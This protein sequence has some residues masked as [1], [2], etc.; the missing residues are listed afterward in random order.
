MNRRDP[1]V[2]R[3]LSSLRRRRLAFVVRETAARVTRIL[4]IALG[5]LIL[6]AGAVLT[7]LPGHVGLPLL[8]LGLMVVLRNS[9]QARRRFIRWQKRHPK[10][11]FPI[12]RLMRREPE[13][14][15]VAWQQLLRSEKVVLRRPGW[16]VL[17][18]GRKAVR[19]ALGKTPL[20]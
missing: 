14:L 4:L 6:L 18:R 13:I 15:L 9:F 12:R 11:I 8:V 19:K 1:R 20:S 5:V 7:P 16:R 10:L 3:R 17:K 2:V